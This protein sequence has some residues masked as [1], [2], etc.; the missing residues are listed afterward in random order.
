MRAERLVRDRCARAAR[1][2]RAED[3]ITLVEGVVAALLLALSSLAL[4]QLVDTSARSNF[5]A[6]QSQA[7][8]NRL[9]AELEEVRALPYQQIA[10]TT[11]P[12]SSGDPNHPGQRIQHSTF[13]GEPLVVNGSTV[14][15]SGDPVSLGKVDPGPEPF[16]IGDIKGEIYRYV[17]WTDADCS[18]TGGSESCGE[19]LAKRVTIAAKLDDNAVATGRSYQEVQGEVVDTE[20]TPEDNPPPPGD[21]VEGQVAEL[22]LTDTPC[23]Y[24]ERQPITGDHLGHNTRGRCRDGHKTGNSAGAPDLLFP[25]APAWGGV[26]EPTYDYA[27]ELEPAD[28]GAEPDIGLQMPWAT[29]DSCL[30]QPVLNLVNGI[31]QPVLGTPDPLD[32]LLTLVGGDPNKYARVHTWLSP[33][34]RNQGG[35]LL[36]QGTLDLWTKTINGAVHPGEICVS[37]FI[38]QKVQVSVLPKQLCLP[39]LGC[40]QLD[41]GIIDLTKTPPQVCLPLVGCIGLEL[42]L[43]ELELD[44]P[45]INTLG[46]TGRTNPP[47]EGGLECDRGVNPL[48]ELLRLTYFRCKKNPWPQEW[49]KLSIPLDFLG[50]NT[51]GQLIPEVLPRDSQIG[52]SLMVRKAGTQ[53]G[54]GLEFMYDHPS[55]QSRLQ[56]RTDKLLEFGSLTG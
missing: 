12:E 1:R 38:R 33:P 28:A 16:A 8:N 50:V 29:T 22:W 21:P 47:T 31:V 39:L 54:S 23:S 55:F 32:G 11:A 37:V 7:L 40:I 53:P 25:E 19:G 6:E 5:R 43:I 27:T 41:L 48:G 4:L 46:L 2:L 14:P 51:S 13:D 44:V 42:S 36:G 45:L 30:L 3:G 26:D 52:V 17:T 35:V 49:T 15:G 34:I 9:Q 18:T 10:L 56:L 24:S 20:V